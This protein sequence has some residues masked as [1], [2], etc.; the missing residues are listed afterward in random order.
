MTENTNMP[1]VGFEAK[2]LVREYRFLVRRALNET[3]E[4]TLTMVNE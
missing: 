4:S 2:A 1:Y 3:C